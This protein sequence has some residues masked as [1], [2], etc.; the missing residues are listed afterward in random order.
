MVRMRSDPAAVSKS[1]QI[2]HQLGTYGNS[3]LVFAILARVTVIGN[4]GGDPG[5]RRSLE[6][7]DHYQQ[8]HYVA[9]H[10]A[11]SGL[12]D[13]D[14]LPTDVL[15][16]LK[17]EFPV[18]EGCHTGFAQRHFQYS[19]DFPRERQIGIARKYSQFQKIRSIS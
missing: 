9:V 18:A 11:T 14:I 2:R 5:C 8:F 3:G 7:V 6:G 17:I 10:R 16:N 13:K 12:N 1:A 19:A 4:Y 15:Q